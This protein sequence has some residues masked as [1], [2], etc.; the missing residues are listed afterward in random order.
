MPTPVTSAIERTYPA[1]RSRVSAVRADLRASLIDC[2]R[3]DDII[4]CASELAT[5]AVIHSRSAEP[6]GTITVTADIRAGDH[7]RIEVHDDGGP[8]TPPAGSA[9]RPH[10]LYIVDVLASQWGVIETGT[11]RTVWA[12]LD[13]LTA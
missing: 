10:G 5:N 2:A 1:T 7:V 11:G 9:G 4:L 3:A 8:W 12:Q 6:G 13:W